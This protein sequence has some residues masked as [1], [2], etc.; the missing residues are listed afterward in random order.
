MI[1]ATKLARGIQVFYVV[2]ILLSCT[3]LEAN[4]TSVPLSSIQPASVYAYY[5]VLN[6]NPKAV[7]ASVNG[8]PPEPAVR[9]VAESVVS[10]DIPAGQSSFSGVLIFEPKIWPVHDPSIQAYTDL[11][12]RIEVDGNSV[13]ERGLDRA[14]PPMQFS[15][16]VSGGKKL[17]LIAMSSYAGSGGTFVLA[18]AQFSPDREAAGSRYLPATGKGYVDYTPAPRQALEGAYFPGENVTVS[19]SFAGPATQANVLLRLAPSTIGPLEVRLPM[20]LRVTN[21]VAQASATWQVPSH[22]G[23]ALL[24]VDEELNGQSVF[25]EETRIAIISHTDISKIPTSTFGVH[26]SGGGAPILDDNFA[27]LWGAKLARVFVRWPI[28]EPSPDQMDFSRID[29]LVDL[30][31]SQSM[32]LMVVL[33]ED[34]PAWAGPPGSPGY[35]TAW[36][37]YVSEVVKHLAG[38]VNHW[39]VFNE[40]DVKY[41]TP[42]I[43]GEPNWDIEVLRAGLQAIHAADPYART[44]CCSTGTSRWLTYDKHLYDAGLLQDIDILSLHPYRAIAP[45]VKLGSYSYWEEVGAPVELAKS[46]GVSRPIWATEANWIIGPATDP[47]INSPGLAGTEQAKYIV[48]VNLLSQIEGVPYF[49]HAPFTHTLPRIYVDA[50]AA[51]ANMTSLMSGSSNRTMLA[52]GPNLWGVYY[53]NGGGYVG[54]LWSAAP[55]AVVSLHGENLYFM[56]IDGNRL[57]LTGDSI[58]VTDSPIYFRSSS[59]PQYQLVQQ[60]RTIQWTQ[61]GGFRWTC[62]SGSRCSSEGKNAL[63]VVGPPIVYSPSLI[64]SPIAVRPGSCQ[65]VRVNL[66]VKQ[67]YVGFLAV[68]SSS[69]KKLGTEYASF[70]PDG[71]IHGFEFRFQTGSASSVKLML[72][73]GNPQ[74]SVSEF[75]VSDFAMGSN[76]Y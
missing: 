75:S 25:H 26:I 52:S 34:G 32:V 44:V 24:T 41:G 70:L 39:D 15:I 14:E 58:N 21:G 13:L 3:F 42:S 65:A 18:R 71:T 63:H 62:Q 73:N 12:L 74:P 19:A 33:G 51:Y 60:P 69:G 36:K 47:N 37:H 9:F 35:M 66:A 48:R 7:T 57:N 38:K 4:A 59:I 49:I 53:S 64:S 31:R 2:I 72:A 10:Y 55:G 46:R 22:L 5:P 17:T 29:A 67:G 50:L 16:P 45:E 61:P 40:V 27:Y 76:C 11:L 23:P 68:D 20:E 54:A 28:L 56:D 8:G 43:K 6:V 30:Y 1:A